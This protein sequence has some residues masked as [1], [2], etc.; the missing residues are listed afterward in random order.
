MASVSW[1]IKPDPTIKIDIVHNMNAENFTFLGSCV[2]SSGILHNEIFFRLI[3]VDGL[4]M[5]LRNE[6][7][8]T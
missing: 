7:G 2:L 5:R 1:A 6:R 3:R 8:I 4:F